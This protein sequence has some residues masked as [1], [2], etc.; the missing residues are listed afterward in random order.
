QDAV[1]IGQ[2]T[3]NVL[4]QYLVDKVDVIVDRYPSGNWY[5]GQNLDI[6]VLTFQGTLRKINRGPGVDTVAVDATSL[7]GTANVTTRTDGINYY[8]FEQ[9]NIGTG[10]GSE[11]FNVQGTSPGSNGFG[12]T[13]VTNVSLNAGDDRVFVSSNSDLDQASWQGQDFLTGNLDD[14]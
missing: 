4:R 6:Y 13:A 11:V 10:S 8:G 3:D 1:A 12:G 5:P 2:T 14:V 7:G 9:I